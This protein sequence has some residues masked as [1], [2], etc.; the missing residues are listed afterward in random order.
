M[1]TTENK[2]EISNENGCNENGSNQNN[3]TK[4][5]EKEIEDN[6]VSETWKIKG[7]PE[8]YKTG[9]VS[10]IM[11]LL[12]LEIVDAFKKTPNN[13]AYVRFKSVE[14]KLRAK[15][16][17]NGYTEKKIKRLHCIEHPN[18]PQY[19]VNNL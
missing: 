11:T 8:Y 1:A 13:T 9:H 15:D 19:E 10:N 18:R 3:K 6:A 14:E 4:N 12:K 2:I 16:I 17:I 7:F 5:G